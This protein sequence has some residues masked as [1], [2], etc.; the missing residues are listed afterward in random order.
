MYLHFPGE[1]ST[2]KVEGDL[3]F[4]W[5]YVTFSRFFLDFS[6]FFGVQDFLDFSSPYAGTISQRMSEVSNGPT[7]T[8]EVI[9]CLVVLQELCFLMVPLIH[10]M[11][12]VS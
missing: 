3:G 11:L 9:P 10:G 5:E 4:L 12:S 1:G 7:Q 8:T 6:G 2:T